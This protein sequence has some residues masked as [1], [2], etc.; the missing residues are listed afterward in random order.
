MLILFVL[1]ITLLYILKYVAIQL[2]ST[3]A[4]NKSLAKIA[5]VDTLPIVGNAHLFMRKDGES[6]QRTLYRVL[7][8]LGMKM[9]VNGIFRLQLF[10]FPLI[11][12]YDPSYVRT[13]L[14]SDLSTTNKG[15]IYGLA[16]QEWLKTG[17]VTAN[18][19]KWK[20][21]RRL[22][23]PVFH[24]KSLL[25][26]IPAVNEHSIALCRQ[27][28]AVQAQT[29]LHETI[30]L[31]TLSV[32]LDFAM[33]INPTELESSSL[34]KYQ[35]AIKQFGTSMIDKAFNPLLW[36]D[37]SS[38][39]TPNGRALRNAVAS[40]HDLS[41]YVARKRMGEYLVSEKDDITNKSPFLDHLL[42]QHFN[43]GSIDE[44]GI[45]EEIDTFTFA[46]HETTSS[47]I[48]FCLFNIAK[49]ENVSEKLHQELLEVFEDQTANISER[50]IS[51]EDLSNLKYLEC[52]IKESLRLYP[53]TPMILRE[54]MKDVTFEDGKVLPKGSEVL[55]HV[56]LL[57]MN[58]QQF[59]DPLT[60]NPERFHCDSVTQRHP[61]AFIPFSGGNRSCI[62]QRFAMIE[63]KVTIANILRK[64]QIKISDNFKEILQQSDLTL[65]TVHP[66][67][68]TFQKRKCL[69]SD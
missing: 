6:R 28:E 67:S 19:S 56:P 37:I 36:Y 15:S 44:E 66:I 29:S 32:I 35:D 62:A 54:L 33:G 5:S 45:K 47:A 11:V 40:L 53:P 59:P 39:L 22:L 46:G 63:L 42:D 68:L 69:L 23:T 4:L 55:I 26:S 3:Y 7:M 1:S 38:I 60:F 51:T 24:S 14:S 57:H 58:E 30:S 50:K 9:K 17:L 43:H 34:V 65:R 25:L 8:E 48:S 41:H 21:R 13:I 20:S 49:H 61:F 16:L 31:Y 18:G 64:F 12:I 10:H 52:V 2:Y 27:L